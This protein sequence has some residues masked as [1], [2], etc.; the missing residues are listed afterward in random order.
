MGDMRTVTIIKGNLFAISAME[1]GDPMQWINIARVNGISDPFI[2][3]TTQLLI[4]STSSVFAD[5]IGPQ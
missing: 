2:S 4:P 3:Q 5:G 1:L